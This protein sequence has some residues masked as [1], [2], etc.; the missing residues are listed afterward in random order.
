[1]TS[2]SVKQVDQQKIWKMGLVAIVA[3]VIANLVAF[4][5]LNAILDLPSAADFPSLSP[6]PIAL[7]TTVFTFIGVVVFAIIARRAAN[8]LRTFWIVAT[9]AFVVSIIPNLLSILNPTALPLPFPNPTSLGFAV[10][11]VFHVI[12]YVITVWVMTTKTVVD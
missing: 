6:L 3:S 12:A 10:L 8:P 9:V 4:F 1:M 5:I 11:I 2:Q 7:L